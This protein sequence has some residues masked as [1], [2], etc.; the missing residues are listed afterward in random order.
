MSDKKRGRPPI[1]NDMR[2][3][4][5]IRLS[6]ELHTQVRVEAAKRRLAMNQFVP[7]LLI[8]GLEYIGS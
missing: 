1:K 5:H 2:V 7:K 3:V 6:E 4:L 8:K